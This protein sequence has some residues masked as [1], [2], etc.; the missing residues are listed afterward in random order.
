[1]S[2]YG[3]NMD[4]LSFQFWFKHTRML[5]KTCITQP[6]YN[7]YSPFDTSILLEHSIMMRYS[8]TVSI[9]RRIYMHRNSLVTSSGLIV[10]A[11]SLITTVNSSIHN[12]LNDSA[13]KLFSPSS[14]IHYIT[15]LLILASQ[16][17]GE[18]IQK[19]Q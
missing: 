13:I 17:N 11:L 14:C 2:G 5:H 16:N 12:T 8:I 9:Y 1:V 6:T 7:Y 19:F 18:A 10:L 15:L 3:T 4:C